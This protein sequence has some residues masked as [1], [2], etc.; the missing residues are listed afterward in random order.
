RRPRRRASRASRTSWRSSA[1][2]ASTSPMREPEVWTLERLL[3][4]DLGPAVIWATPSVA[5][6]VAAAL[7]HPLL[8]PLAGLPTTTRTLIAVGGGTLIDAAKVFRVETAPGLRLIAI[9]SVWGSGAEA[10]P[11]AVA[12][13]G[14][15]KRIRVGTQ[16][17]PDVRVLWP[18]LGDSLPD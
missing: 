13:D 9:P 10:S 7:P 17:V 4:E 18:E 2:R 8:E 15:R 11:V 16:Y 12:Q 3:A 5:G 1:P 14:L 6:R